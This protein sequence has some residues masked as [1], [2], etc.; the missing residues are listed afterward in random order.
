MTGPC[1]VKSFEVIECGL[2]YPL[3]S[4]E[5]ELGMPT[6]VADARPAQM[7]DTRFSLA[8]RSPHPNPLPEGREER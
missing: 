7:D 5:S 1:R 2:P 6:R 3:K 8:A 4:R